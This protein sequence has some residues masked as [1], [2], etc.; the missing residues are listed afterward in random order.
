M[1]VLGTG[2]DTLG[3]TEAGGGEDE[4]GDA[5]TV[6]DGIACGDDRR[7]DGVGTGAG[8]GAFISI[9]PSTLFCVSSSVP[10]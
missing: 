9:R 8:V 5:L 4:T 2:V 7:G 6:V 10:W 3:F 1:L